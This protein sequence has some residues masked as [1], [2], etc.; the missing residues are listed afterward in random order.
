MLAV[1]EKA[2]SLEGGLECVLTERRVGIL[3][4]L[5]VKHL[6]A[7]GYNAKE[8]P[9]ERVHRDISTWEQNTFAEYCGRDARS[10]PERWH[11]LTHPQKTGHSVC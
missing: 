7:R 1:H 8:K 11:K 5:R 4:E 6:V 2:M 9:V 3:A 10:R